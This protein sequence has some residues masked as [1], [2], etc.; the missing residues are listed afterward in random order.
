[1]IYYIKFYKKNF[2]SII[3]AIIVSTAINLS[4]FVVFPVTFERSVTI[5]LLNTLAQN[6]LTK[7]QLQ[8]KLI[9][10]YVI[11]NKTVD[12][13][14]IEQE[15]IHMISDDQNYLHLTKQG[16]NFLKFSEIIKKIY[17]I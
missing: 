10:E 14:V 4:I 3:A 1:M 12:K 2:E 17:G 15:I 16:I 8:N 11:K 7:S 9:N 5:Y 13:R 6:Q